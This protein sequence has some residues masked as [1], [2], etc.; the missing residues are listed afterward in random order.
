[1]TATSGP[2]ISL[3]TESIGYAAI[4]ETPCVIVD[5]QRAGPSTGQGYT[6]RPR[7]YNASE[8]GDA[9]AMWKLLLSLLGLCKKCMI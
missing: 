3:M 4:T 5:V 2:G 7:R 6:P 9:M 8:V 1:M